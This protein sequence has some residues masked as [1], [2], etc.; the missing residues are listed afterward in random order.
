MTHQWINSKDDL[1]KHDKEVM[2]VV[3]L[4]DPYQNIEKPGVYQRLIATGKFDAR[5]GWW[6]RNGNIMNSM[7]WKSPPEWIKWDGVIFWKEFD[8]ETFDIFKQIARPA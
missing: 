7:A 4:H 3:Y 6:V 8:S 2:V 5:S 1:P